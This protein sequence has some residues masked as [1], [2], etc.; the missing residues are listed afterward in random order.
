MLPLATLDFG[1]TLHSV[2][3]HEDGAARGLPVQLETQLDGSRGIGLEYAAEVWISG[4]RRRS[5]APAD[6]EPVIF[7]SEQ[8]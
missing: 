1:L 5:P 7:N 8:D 2:G 3:G 4:H 6:G